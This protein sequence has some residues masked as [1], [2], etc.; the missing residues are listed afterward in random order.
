[1]KE[2]YSKKMNGKIEGWMW[3]THSTAFIWS[4]AAMRE[5]AGCRTWQACMLQ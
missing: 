3:R 2:C 4:E 5:K 1:M